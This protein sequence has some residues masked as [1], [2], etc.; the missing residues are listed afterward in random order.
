M[1]DLGDLG[2]RELE[3][4]STKLYSW[5]LSWKGDEDDS[6]R[7]DYCS[8]Y[9]IFLFKGDFSGRPLLLAFDGTV[10]SLFWV[11]LENLGD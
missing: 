1:G 3:G 9:I 6:I 8:Y 7:S 10:N 4:L 5:T 11:R 2:F